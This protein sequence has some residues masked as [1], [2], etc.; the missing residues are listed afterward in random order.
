MKGL[1]AS[2]Q[3]ETFIAGYHQA[4][5]RGITTQNDIG[6]IAAKTI[7]EMHLG[8]VKLL[9]EETSRPMLLEVFLD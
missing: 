8:V 5:A 6:Y 3:R 2:S 4:D 9:T 7:D 1:A